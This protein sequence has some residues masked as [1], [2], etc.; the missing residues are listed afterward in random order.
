VLPTFITWQAIAQGE[1]EEI[2]PNCNIPSLNGYCVYPENRFLP[3]RARA[4]I[5]FLVARFETPYWDN[6]PN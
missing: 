5:D 3:K 4:L 6:P 2:L 1:L